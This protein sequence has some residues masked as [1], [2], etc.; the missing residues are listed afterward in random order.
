LSVSVVVFAVPLSVFGWFLPFPF[1]ARAGRLWGQINLHGL[2]LICGLGYRI[3]GLDRLP[4]EPCIVL[5]KHQSAWETIALQA[6]L[7]PNHTWVIKRELLWTPFF[8]WA[9]AAYRPIAID[10]SAGRKAVKQLLDQG[11]ACLEAGRWVVI[12]P[13]GTRVAPGQ[14]GRYGV[15]GALLAEKTGYPVLPIAHNAGVFWRRR[16][17]L[18]YPGVVDLVIGEAV[19]SQGRPAAAINRWVEDWIEAKVAELPHSREQSVVHQD[20]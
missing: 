20:G 11:R 10:R 13:E 14:R 1:L 17:F 19:P 15:G 2:D 5:C 6:L 3:R 16:G 7:P 12:F 9:L 18:K 8:G 4:S